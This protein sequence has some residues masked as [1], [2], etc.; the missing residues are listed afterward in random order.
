MQIKPIHLAIAC[1]VGALATPVLAQTGTV[2][3]GDG[4]V[5]HG[6]GSGQATV[7]VN[8]Q[9]INAASGEGAVAET[10]IGSHSSTVRGK[11]G[12]TTITTTS[13]PA[14]AGKGAG[15]QDY[16]NVDLSG[17][18]FAN[19]KLAGRT[20]TNVDLSR[21]NLQGAD[22]RNTTFVNVE[23]TGAN[24]SGANLTGAKLVNT[25][26][27]DAVTTGTIWEGRR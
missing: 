10:H 9:V 21:A 22:L 17:R 4:T 23:L 15:T 14:Q 6:D 16:V 25:D 26:T 11:A 12:Q 2:S 27:S 20:F 1:A 8:G 3:L 13:T 24:L 7:R 18:N 19:A 5:I